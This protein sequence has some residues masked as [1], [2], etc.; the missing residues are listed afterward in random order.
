MFQAVEC[1]F[2]GLERTFHDVERTFRVVEYKLM[3][4]EKLIF[5]RKRKVILTLW[6]MFPAFIL[7]SFQF[8]TA[9]ICRN[10]AVG[11]IDAIGIRYGSEP[12]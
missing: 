7:F 4:K 5:L 12:R 11:T 1:T 2:Q 9:F 6:S 3:R 8:I 10:I